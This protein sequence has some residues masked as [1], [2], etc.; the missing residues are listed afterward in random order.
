MPRILRLHEQTGPSGLSLDDVPL[1]EP[2]DDEL[3]VKVLAFALNWGDMDLMRGV[4]TVSL[5]SLP[6]RI[7]GEVVGIVDALGKNVSADWM[8]QRVCS[9][10]YFHAVDRG[11]SG[12]FAIIH[13]DYVTAAQEGLSH[14]DACSVW[15]QYATGYFPIVEYGNVNPGTF[16]LIIAATSSAGIGAIQMA[17]A[18]GAKTI[19]TTR[20][21]NN[22]D[23]LMDVGADHVIVT[24]GDDIADELLEMTQGAG[25]DF[26]YDA[27]G[28]E[29]SA[30]YAPALAQDALIVMFGLLARQPMVI[31]QM[32][33]TAKNTTVR[34]YSVQIH[35]A[36][37]ELLNRS[38][39]YVNKG[40]DSGDL[41]P[42]VDRCFTLDNYQDAFAYQLS[43]R[44]AHGKIVVETGLSE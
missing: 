17:K 43:E 3:R 20:N 12:E 31:P 16:S 30:E 38:V 28:G 13:K 34:F 7:G 35:N 44:T 32:A 29:F 9:L 6:A 39:E 41:V 36:N 8:G 1:E 42:I 15:A 21:E 2:G 11:L 27:I 4:Y 26:V 10:P 25:I 33:L 22:R 14:V 23:F 40:L 5:D 24:G 19:G 37:I 18:R